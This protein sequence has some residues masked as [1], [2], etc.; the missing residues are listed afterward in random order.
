METQINILIEE[1][2]KEL[3]IR[4][5]K[6]VALPYSSFCRSASVEKARNILKENLESA[7]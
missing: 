4:A 7:Q 2:D 3:V 5:S 6:I 1:K